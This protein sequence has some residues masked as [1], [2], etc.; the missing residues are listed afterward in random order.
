MS[1]HSEEML[2]CSDGEEDGG[3]LRVSRNLEEPVVEATVP[4]ESG[5]G[6]TD[7]RTTLRSAYTTG[8]NQLREQ[9]ITSGTKTLAMRD[10][11]VTV[12]AESEGGHTGLSV[13]V[14][15]QDTKHVVEARR[16]IPDAL[17][18][19]ERN[20]GPVNDAII[21]A[22]NLNEG[23]KFEDVD[24]RNEW[25]RFIGLSSSNPSW[26]R[27]HTGA[28][29]EYMIKIISPDEFQVWQGDASGFSVGEWMEM[30]YPN[31]D[32]LRERGDVYSRVFQEDLQQFQYPVSR[33]L[34]SPIKE[35]TIGELPQFIM[36]QYLMSRD[37][38]GGGK[39]LSRD[40]IG[41]FFNFPCALGGGVSVRNDRQEVILYEAGGA[42]VARPL[43]G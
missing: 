8:N 10:V 29:H 28:C 18:E 12:S 13:T 11:D 37:R 24:L 27:V 34:Q 39:I 3:P 26:L 7:L 19:C 42:G 43:T 33:D 36:E 6:P 15:H 25:Q 31:Q 4:E 32:F 40:Q 41:E 38:Y 14:E 5:G 21:Q 1:P 22:F 16:E 17:R 9:S 20:C 23:Q 2:S 35:R 30:Q